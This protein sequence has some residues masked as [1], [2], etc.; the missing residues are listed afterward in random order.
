[1]TRPRRAV[2]YLRA[3]MIFLA[4]LLPMLSLLPL[5]WLWLWERGFLLYWF[6]GALAVGALAYVIESRALHVKEMAAIGPSG[7]DGEPGGAD[8]DPGWTLREQRAWVAVEAIA[9]DVRPSELNN[10]DDIIGL[11]IKTVEA[12]A[13]QIHPEDPAPLW[14]FTIPEALALIERVSG[15][16]RP[17]VRENI[18]LGD[19]LTVGQ[20][21]KI[22]EWRSAL[23]V[24]EK[25]YDIWRI[26]RLMNPAAA[27][28]QEAREQLTRRLYSGLRTELAKRLAQ[29]YVREVGRAAIDLY[30]GRLKVPSHEL[31]EHVTKTTLRDRKAGAMKPA[32][33]L[34]IM[35]A[36]RK[37]TGKTSLVAALSFDV[38]DVVE[39][40]RATNEY[41][42]H[43]IKLPKMPELL[44]VDGPAPYEPADLLKSLLERAGDSDLIVWVLSAVRPDRT[45]D[46]NAIEAIRGYF[47]GL[48][49]RRLPPILAV[50]THIDHLQVAGD[51][52]P[53]GELLHSNSAKAAAVRSV[54][55]DVA[56]DLAIAVGDIV[57]VSVS[58]DSVY[59]LEAVVAAI[60]VRLPEMRRAQIVRLM[61]D[62]APGWSLKRLLRQTA[63]AAR[64]VSG[65]GTK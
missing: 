16:M 39:V 42:A 53:A 65:F 54:C 22:Y 4:L 23:D 36:G 61:A 63:N 26:I 1:M 27:V 48:A 43:P 17:F 10:R 9:K 28:A 41:L 6:A 46:R 29:G 8:V 47:E 51:W 20:V 37:G 25:A 11:G 5:G 30:G 50:V 44:V 18:P 49:N 35:I 52:P 13:R 62:A 38:Q 21:R 31:A 64:S 3:L 56:N 57:P 12:V 14:K 34:R 40:I 58:A 55:T 7:S 59:N 33:P 15:E 45:A 19:Q 32:E 24:A 60:A 2:R